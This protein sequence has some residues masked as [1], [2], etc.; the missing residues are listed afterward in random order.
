MLAIASEGHHTTVIS[1]AM[2]LERCKQLADNGW[3]SVT[4]LAVR[5]VDEGAEDTVS[6]T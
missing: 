1:L 3:P 5:A 4:E 6:A 2:T